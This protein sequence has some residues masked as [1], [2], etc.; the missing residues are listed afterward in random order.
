MNPPAI[1]W[2][3]VEKFLRRHDSIPL[4]HHSVLHH[5]THIAQRVDVG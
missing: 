3:A 2:A 1:D 5:E 4:E